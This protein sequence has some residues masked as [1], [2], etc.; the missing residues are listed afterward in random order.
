M[1]GVRNGVFSYI[2]SLRRSGYNF[3][4]VAAQY[5]GYS[6][7][8]SPPSMQECALIRDWNEHYAWPR[9][10]SRAVHEFLEQINTKYGDRLPVYRAAYPDWWTD[11][12]GSAAP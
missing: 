12:F 9:L 5:S 2:R 3:P 10:R 6:T 1:E 8:N 11:G 4:L 7:D